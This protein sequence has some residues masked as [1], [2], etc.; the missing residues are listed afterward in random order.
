MTKSRVKSQSYV[1]CDCK[2]FFCKK[3]ICCF[4]AGRI[5]QTLL[6]PGLLIYETIIE[7]HSIL[8][9]CN[10]TACC[11]T[12]F[13]ARWKFK[14]C[15]EASFRIW[16]YILLSIRKKKKCNFHYSWQQH[17]GFTAIHC[18]LYPQWIFEIYL[19]LRDLETNPYNTLKFSC[20][21]WCLARLLCSLGEHT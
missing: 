13:C 20:C 7:W 8:I 10:S 3:N 12:S 1:F 2:T 19:L 14:S 15:N 11:F 5:Q 21:V 18:E 6:C 4:Q 17:S 9:F 16:G